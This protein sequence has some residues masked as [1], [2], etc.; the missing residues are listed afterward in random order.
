MLGQWRWINNIY[1]GMDMDPM[2][3]HWWWR[4]M[5]ACMAPMIRLGLFNK[6]LFDEAEF[7]IWSYPLS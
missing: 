2:I 7:F 6:E 3:G 4:T 5:H 1:A